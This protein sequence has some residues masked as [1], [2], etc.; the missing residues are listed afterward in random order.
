MNQEIHTTAAP[1]E[2][3]TDEMELRYQDA[4][5]QRQRAA[6]LYWGHDDW[7]LEPDDEL[8]D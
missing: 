8:D 2:V 6:Q 4:R 3:E 5:A 1:V 7:I